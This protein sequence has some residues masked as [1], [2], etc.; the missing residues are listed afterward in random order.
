MKELPVN[1]LTS[2]DEAINDLTLNRVEEIEGM[3][4]INTKTMYSY[5]HAGLVPIK[6]IDLPRMS[7]LK[8][9]GKYKT[10]I[11]KRKRGTS[12]DQRP[13]EVENR[14]EFGHWEG[15]LVTGPRDGKNGALLTLIERKTRFYC[16]IPIKDKTSK[17]VYMAINKLAK[18]HGENFKNIFNSTFYLQFSSNFSIN[19]RSHFHRRIDSLYLYEYEQNILEHVLQHE[20]DQQLQLRWDNTF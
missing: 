17:Q 20:K 9:T 14:V 7:S 8:K 1:K 5:V 18:K 12:I 19:N 10:Y 15:D 2:I 11:C 6:P 4:T 13:I 3:E 16:M